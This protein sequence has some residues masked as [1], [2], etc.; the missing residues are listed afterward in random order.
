MSF[1]VLI[2]NGTVVDGTGAPRYRADVAITDG[3]IA[4]IG[5][6]NARAGQVIDASDLTVAPGIIDHHTHY[7]AQ[8]CWDPLITCSSWHGVTSVIMGNCG[9]GLAPCRPEARDIAAWDLVNVEGIPFDVLSKGVTWDWVSFPDY[10]DAAQAR[11]SGINLG[12]MAALSPFRHYVMGEESMERAATPE[13]SRR[14]AALLREAMDAGAFG[15]SM[16][17]GPQHIGYEGRPLASRLASRDE[18]KIYANVLRELRRGTIQLALN[19]T[20][21]MVSESDYALLDLLLTESARPLNGLALLQRDD[22]PEACAETLRG[23]APLLERGLVAQVSARPLVIQFDLRS[24]FLFA[25]LPAWG[26]AFNQPAETQKQ[27]YLQP[28]FRQEF[29]DELK[30]PRLFSDATLWDRLQ[31]KDVGSPALR[32]FQWKT[33]AEVARLRGSDP[34]DTFLDLAIEDE[35]NTQFTMEVF[36]ANEERVP[37]LITDP[38]TMIGLSDGGAHVD[39]LCD[40]GYGT[41]LLGTWVR[42]K[43]AMTLEYAVKRLTSEPADFYGIAGRGRI[44][45]GMAADIMIFDAD[46]VGSD[47]LPEMRHD[48]PGGGRRLVVQAQ[49]VEYTLVNGQ[50]LYDEGRHTGAM[51]GR[52]LRSGG[53]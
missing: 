50:V 2:K 5:K 24:P 3:M 36:N 46:T 52:V 15:F 16:T 53:G 47:K 42:E 23:I 37:E 29:R 19:D 7:D 38:R 39:T 21:S 35:L 49:G 31:V 8:I 48:L 26:P 27:L 13:E 6:V 12:F 11:G 34:L 30:R 40:A 1:D 44:A 9:V 45:T 25:N 32:T 14:I 22:D 20:P 43:G 33:V 4:E 28:A 10:L 51:P 41:Y 18:L 17:N